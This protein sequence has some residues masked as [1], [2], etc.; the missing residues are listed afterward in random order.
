MEDETLMEKTHRLLKESGRSLPDLHAELHNNG[1]TITFYW[2]RKF[3]SRRVQ[4]PS[5]N[6]VEEL[7]RHLT[8][9]PLLKAS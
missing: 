4:D 9:Q 6:K 3:S 1:S 8:G 2:L 5:V 7:Y